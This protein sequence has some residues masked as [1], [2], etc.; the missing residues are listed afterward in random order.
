MFKNLK[1]LHSNI[2]HIGKEITLYEYT[3]QDGR[4]P[5]EIKIDW[6]GN[7]MQGVYGRIFGDDKNVYH[8][9][10][11]SFGQ[12]ATIYANRGGCTSIEDNKIYFQVIGR[13]DTHQTYF[14]VLSATPIYPEP[15]TASQVVTISAPIKEDDFG[16]APAFYS[17]NTGR[18]VYVMEVWDE[19]TQQFIQ[20]VK[21]KLVP[22]GYVTLDGFAGGV[23]V[24]VDLGDLDFRSGAILGL[25]INKGYIGILN[26]EDMYGG[27]GKI[28]AL[29]VQKGLGGLFTFDNSQK[30]RFI[31]TRANVQQ[32]AQQIASIIKQNVSLHGTVRTKKTDAYYSIINHMYTVVKRV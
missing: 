18:V 15:T 3:L 5:V 27:L 1:K 9:A 19:E 26:F 31:E 12:Y 17:T 11:F 24:L 20:Q 4:M 13:P 23:A 8:T 30:L 32:V 21:S 28:E 25:E 7:W 22:A 6:E 14:N 29:D 2:N 16:S 10:L